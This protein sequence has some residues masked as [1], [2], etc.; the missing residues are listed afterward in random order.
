MID[1]SETK[2]DGIIFDAEIYIEGYSIVRC[3]R[4]MTS[5][6]ALKIFFLKMLKPSLWICSFENQALI[7]SYSWRTSYNFLQ[8]FAE[9][10]NSPNISKNEIF[11]IGD[12]NVNILQNGVSLLDKKVNTS[13]GKIVINSDVKSY[14]EFCSM[15]GLKQL[16]RYL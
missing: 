1:I 6:S 16:I 4:D 9:I 11:V 5:V 10:L 3:D 14:F 7:C 2:L 13:K 15:L 12:M 8:L